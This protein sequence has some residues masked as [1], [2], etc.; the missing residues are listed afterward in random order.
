MFWISCHVVA[1]MQ[2]SAGEVQPRNLP[3]YT[4]VGKKT[5]VPGFDPRRRVSVGQNAKTLP[6]HPNGTRP[7]RTQDAAAN[8]ERLG[9]ETTTSTSPPKNGRAA[10]HPA[11]DAYRSTLGESPVT[12]GRFGEAAA[13]SHDPRATHPQPAPG[14]GRRRNASNTARQRRR[15][16]PDTK[17]RRRG[18][19]QSDPT[20]EACVTQRPF[21]ASQQWRSG[22]V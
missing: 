7:H 3:P 20:S 21:Q 8:R 16:R 6:A 9:E 19:R 22:G 5:R 12:A 15:R 17:K 2:P 11:R 14:R 18:A 13:Y 10:L 4:V 1:P